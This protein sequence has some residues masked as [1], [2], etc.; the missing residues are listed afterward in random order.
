MHRMQC[1][2]IPRKEVFEIRVNREQRFPERITIAL[3]L[4]P[5]L[6]AT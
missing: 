1:Q 2:G 6:T 3:L 5:K 4:R